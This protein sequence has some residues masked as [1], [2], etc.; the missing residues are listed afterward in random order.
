MS[1]TMTTQYRNNLSILSWNIEGLFKG[2]LCKLDIPVINRLIKEFD[3]VCLSETWCNF[4]FYIQGFETY[5]SSR[6]YKHRNAKRESGGVAILVKDEI[7]KYVRKQISS[8]SDTLWVK[9]D[10]V[11]FDMN[12]DLYI[13]SSY[14]I[15]E[16]SSIFSWKD[17]DVCSLLEQDVARYSKLGNIHLGGDLNSRTG[18]LKD[19]INND[20]RDKNLQLPGDYTPDS[21]APTRRNSDIIINN[22]GRWLIDTCIASNLCILNGRTTG[23]LL[24]KFTCY[25]TIGQSTVDYHIVNKELLT[26]VHYFKVLDFTEWSDHCPIASSLNIVSSKL[27]NNVGVKLNKSPAS[28]IWD[29]DSKE[30]YLLSLNYQKQLFDPFM[31]K[32]YNTDCDQAVAD[33]TDILHEIAKPALKRRVVKKRRHRP[34]LGFDNSCHEVRE[35]VMYIKTLMERYPHNRQIKRCFY[36]A[37]KSLYKKLRQTEFKFKNDILQRLSDLKEKDSAEYWRLLN[38]LRKEPISDPADKVD[39]AKWLSHFRALLKVPENAENLYKQDLALAENR[40]RKYSQLDYD[41]SEEEIVK[42]IRSLKNNKSAG[43]DGIIN[44]M[45]KVGYKTI[46]KP[47][48]KLLQVVFDSKQF[49]SPWKR[50]IIAKIFKSGDPYDTDNYRGVTLSSVLGKLFSLIMTNRLQT[51]LESNDKLHPAQGGF[52]KDHRTADNLFIVSQIVKFYKN[53]KKPLYSCFVD[54]RKAFDMLNREAL[55]I[56]LLQMEI[57]GKFYSIVKDMHINNYCCVK[58][59]HQYITEYFPSD[60]GVKQG[61][62]ISPT[63]F[64]IFINDLANELQNPDCHPAK[65]NDIQLGCLLYADDLLILSETEHG[66]RKGLSILSDF[67]ER[68]SLTVNVKKSKIL[69]FNKKKVDCGPFIVNGESL[70]I[71]KSYRYLG[72]I[73]S[74][75]GSFKAGIQNLSSKALKCSFLLK[76]KLLLNLKVPAKIYLNCFETLVKPVLLYC[77]EVWGQ[78]LVHDTKDFTLD[79]VDKNCEPERIHLKFCKSLLRVPATA[80]NVAVRS[81]LG[82]TPVILTIMS[83]ICKYYMR[84]TKMP[85][86]RLVKQI[87]IA[88]ANQKFSLK[89]IATKITTNIGVGLSEQQ[90]YSLKHFNNTVKSQLLF[91]YEDDWFTYIS[92]PKGKCG[93]GNKLRVYQTFKRKYEMEPYLSLVKNVSDCVNLTRLRISAHHLRIESGRYERKNG[94]VL[95][96]CSRICLYCNMN[97]VENEIHMVTK[98]PLYEHLRAPMLKNLKLDKYSEKQIFVTLISAKTEEIATIFSR[99]ISECFNLRLSKSIN[100]R[101]T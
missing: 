93:S 95:P 85:D 29:S 19:F 77:S 38:S 24:G 27:Q 73:V 80:S 46:I 4:K 5:V 33:F 57:G 99:Y 23:D 43:P 74:S 9:V 79:L 69:I 44:E 7:K 30:R 11:G 67:S 41:M 53:K 78:D 52:R 51:D 72:V 42:A 35:H 90:K 18:L 100:I 55:M 101:N 88:T 91:T 56:K 10:K 68:W 15:P 31:H 13:C 6:D 96:E 1:Q 8:S 64:N 34:T 14:L 75:S 48:Q 62:G 71:V 61:D 47:I 82:R 3:I 76:R 49:P 22:Y 97:A 84:L 94:Q 83:N 20:D 2:N 89:N 70:E 17:I 87:L 28:Y 81:E 50:G 58:I 40:Y 12:R 92:S 25:K 32:N 16:K 86:T 21:V 59:N 37:R 98:C 36:Q 66:L 65:I 45:L 26:R 63:L 60:L 54:F 39:P